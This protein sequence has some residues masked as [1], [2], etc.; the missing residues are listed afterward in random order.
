MTSTSHGGSWV[1]ADAIARRRSSLRFRVVTRMVVTG[2][3]VMGVDYI[4]DRILRIHRTS[5]E[6]NGI[7]SSRSSWGWFA[8][9]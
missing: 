8:S 4:A 5:V 3:S 9:T 2:V 7:R 6:G 1:N